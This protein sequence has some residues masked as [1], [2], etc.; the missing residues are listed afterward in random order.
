LASGYGPDCVIV[1]EAAPE[2]VDF[3]E[4]RWLAADSAER[5]QAVK[6]WIEKFLANGADTLVLACTHF[7]LLKEEF[8]SLGGEDLLIF[9][10]VEGVSRRVEFFLDSEDGKLRSGLAEDADPKSPLAEAP[11]MVVTGK[12]PLESHWEQLCRRF[13]FTLEMEC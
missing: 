7:I 5:L 4:H 2:L 6:P 9:D 1:G 10:S 11:L 3:V 12:E 8:Q 13:G